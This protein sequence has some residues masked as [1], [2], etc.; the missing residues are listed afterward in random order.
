V[1]RP[2]YPYSEVRRS[3]LELGKAPPAILQR[4]AF[5]RPRPPLNGA[6]RSNFVMRLRAS[7]MPRESL[8]KRGSVDQRDSWNF[9]RSQKMKNTYKPITVILPSKS[10]LFLFCQQGRPASTQIDRS[11]KPL[12]NGRQN[13][14]LNHPPFTTAKVLAQLAA[15]DR[16]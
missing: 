10:G 1:T 9:Q 4:T 6:M 15:D 14:P 11:K 13:V 7:R 5:T 3:L 2:F 16:T 12:E 8:Y